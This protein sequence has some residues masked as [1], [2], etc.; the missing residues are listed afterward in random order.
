MELGHASDTTVARK[1]AGV[2]TI[3][4]RPVQTSRVITQNAS[5]TLGATHHNAVILHDNTTSYTY[6]LPSGTT[7]FEIG[8]GFQVH[9]SSTGTTI[10][11]GS[12]NAQTI[13]WFKGDGTAPATGNRTG[14]RGSVMTFIKV[15]ASSWNC[16]GGGIS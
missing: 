3:E 1:A 16:Y 5:V 13:N 9:T 2:V 4:G 6:Q 15:A 12:T 14:G 7:V 11:S 10:V 8:D